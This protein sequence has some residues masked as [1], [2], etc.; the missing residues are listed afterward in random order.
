[1]PH[2]GKS[3]ASDPSHKNTAPPAKSRKRLEDGAVSVVLFRFDCPGEH[4]GHSFDHAGHG[5]AVEGE[6]HHISGFAFFAIHEHLF[7]VKRP[8]AGVGV[9]AFC[10]G[11]TGKLFSLFLTLAFL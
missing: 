2:P 8:E 4:D 10:G 9:R 3:Y 7:P 1:M 6:C 11:L 5:L